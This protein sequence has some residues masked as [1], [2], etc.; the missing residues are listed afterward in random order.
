MYFLI[1][2][3]H[4]GLL[5]PNN[6]LCLYVEGATYQPFLKFIL[7]SHTVSY[8]LCPCESEKADASSVNLSRSKFTQTKG[9]SMATR[10]ICCGS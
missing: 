9:S 8:Q 6:M 5:H 7:I 3:S 2:V 4:I 1:F 10:H